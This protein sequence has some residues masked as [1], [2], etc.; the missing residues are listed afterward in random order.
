MNFKLRKYMK[1][2]WRLM[3][4]MKLQ[5]RK[6]LFFLFQFENFAETIFGF[7]PARYQRFAGQRFH[8]NQ[9]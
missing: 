9:A 7:I 1:V 3:A 2:C 8:Q 6:A 4:Q 5:S